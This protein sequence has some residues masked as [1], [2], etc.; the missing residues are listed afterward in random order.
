MLLHFR[1]GNYDTTK[2]VKNNSNFIF[3]ADE[4]DDPLSPKVLRHL[5]LI[6]DEAAE[7]GIKVA[8]CEDRLMA[9]KY[10]YRNPP[11]IT[12]FRKGTEEFNW[13]LNS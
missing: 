9:K 5:E 11:G 10:G 6:D 12:Y 13:M 7:Y 2:G 1:G 4:K 8:K 3:T